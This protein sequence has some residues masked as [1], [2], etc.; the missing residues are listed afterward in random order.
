MRTNLLK[1]TSGKSVWFDLP[2]ELWKIR[3]AAKKQQEHCPKFRGKT[4]MVS[5]GIKHDAIQS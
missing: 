4:K 2:P 1:S 5:K 3:K